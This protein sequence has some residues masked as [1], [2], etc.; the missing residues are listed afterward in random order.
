MKAYERDHR[1]II[2]LEGKIDSV[3]AD[4]TETE[5]RQILA[6][7]PADQLDLDAEKLTYISSSGLRILIRLDKEQPKGVTIRNVSPEVYEIFEVTGINTLMKVEKRKRRISVEDCEVIGEGAFGTVYRLDGDTVVKVYRDG[8]NSLPIIEEEQRRSRQAFLSGIPTAIP[9]DIV[10]VGDQYG[11]VFEM[12]NA[13]NCNDLIAQDPAILPEMIP[14]YAAFLKKLHSKEAGLW[15]LESARDLYLGYLDVFGNLLPA[16][17]EN[18]LREL[19]RSMPEDHHLIH[20]DIQM[21]NVMKAGDEMILIDMDKICTGN[22]VF[23]FAS[24]YAAYI[25]FN[26]DDP[27]D[28]VRFLGIAR[29]TAHRIYNETLRCYLNP[30]DG[31]IPEE[32]ERSIRILGYIRLLKILIIERPKNNS[33][34]KEIRIRHS[35]E[36]LEEL[37]FQTER[38]GI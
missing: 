27:L 36:H 3:N 5:I 30:P 23:E 7:Y 2:E 8:E 14:Q 28:S 25:A 4:R 32:T 21:K 17:T 6:E 16:R 29:E 26:E 12:I 20:G 11:A 1:L 22:P 9:F 13:R 19:L 34:L 15:P 18:R 37:A 38:L 31:K 33:E 10:R 35:V 24:L